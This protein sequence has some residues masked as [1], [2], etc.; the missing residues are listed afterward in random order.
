MA[1]RFA[2]VFEFDRNGPPLSGTKEQQAAVR[3]A[4]K[5]HQ[6]WKNRF[7]RILFTLDVRKNLQGRSFMVISFVDFSSYGLWYLGMAWAHTIQL[8]E[9]LVPE[10]IE[11]TLIHELGHVV[12][13]Q[14]ISPPDRS[15]AWAEEVRH[16]VNAGQPDGATWDRISPWLL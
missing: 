4:F 14:V 15:E 12:G 13:T 8:A 2:R 9:Q 7:D 1:R 16:W 5:K 3:A 11:K 6:S 10:A